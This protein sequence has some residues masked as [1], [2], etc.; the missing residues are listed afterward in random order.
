MKSF[1]VT[2][3]M[4]SVLLASVLYSSIIPSA[5]L[6]EIKK[7]NGPLP[8]DPSFVQYSTVSKFAA[9]S[10]YLLRFIQKLVNW[11][12]QNHHHHALTYFPSLFLSRATLLIQ[13]TLT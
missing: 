12:I 13:D 9:A 10:A 6:A 11:D 7:F 1:G 2:R 8:A 3:K 4:Y 5:V